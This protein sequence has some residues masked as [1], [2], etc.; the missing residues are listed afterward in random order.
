MCLVSKQEPLESRFRLSS[1]TLPNAG[2]QRLTDAESDTHGNRNH[3][4]DE[5]NL[6]DHSVA[7][8]HFGETLARALVDLVGLGLLF[9]VPLAWPD[10]AIWAALGV[11]HRLHPA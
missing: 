8:A 10:L 4:Q 11:A 1:V 9:P 7:L 5:C 6:G 2:T 3:Q